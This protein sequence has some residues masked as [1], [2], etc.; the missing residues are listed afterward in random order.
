MKSPFLQIVEAIRNKR[1]AKFHAQRRANIEYCIKTAK[2][3]FTYEDLIPI[4][5]DDYDRLVARLEERVAKEKSDEPFEITTRFGYTLPN[6]FAW[7]EIVASMKTR[8][9]DAYYIH[10][11]D[12]TPDEDCHHETLVFFC[13]RSSD[14]S[15][16]QLCG[17]EGYM[18]ICP[19]CLMIQG[20]VHYIMN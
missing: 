20:F 5:D 13:F 10:P 17:R 9:R 14:E 1:K 11:S 3:S 2:A 15:W 6:I 16:K 7:R 19:E 18:L 4:P 12:H 8:V